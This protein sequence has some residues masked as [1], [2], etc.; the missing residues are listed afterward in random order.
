MNA[1]S[2]TVKTEPGDAGS[3]IK[4]SRQGK[5]RIQ[6]LASLINHISDALISTNMESNILEWNPVAENI[7]RWRAA[8]VT[9]WPM[10]KFIQTDYINRSREEAVK[11]VLEQVFEYTRQEAMG[12]TSLELGINPDAVGR[13]RITAELQAQGS[14]HNI[15]LEL[16]NKS[17]VK[18]VLLL[19]IDL[20]SIGERNIYSRQHKISPSTK[21]RG[22]AEDRE[23]TFPEIH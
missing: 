18:H 8:E 14:V 5:E 12:K 19:N 7:Y 3:P 23:R 6:Y 10:N 1:K 11:A 16:T 15:E 17:G 13:P 22:D 9:G 21:S 4:K 2:N 20:V